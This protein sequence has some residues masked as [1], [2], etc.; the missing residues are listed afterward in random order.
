VRI[1][2]L[3]NSPEET[4]AIGETLGEAL[5]GGEVIC[6]SGP[7]GAGKTC[8]AQG[9]A[10]G[11]GVPE[12]ACVSSPSFIMINQ[13]RGRVPVYHVDLFRVGSGKEVEDLGLLEFLEG[14]QVT[15]IEWADKATS[16]LPE[17]RIAVRLVIRGESERELVFDVP[18]RLRAPA[19]RLSQHRGCIE[20]R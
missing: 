11:L 15:I 3:S 1:V 8:L 10:R 16:F 17:E 6:L 20:G 9:I 12:D 13:Y 14:P 2:L 5:L 19:A 7:L 18:D 4:A